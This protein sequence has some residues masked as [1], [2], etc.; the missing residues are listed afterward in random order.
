M[1]TDIP[2]SNSAY[3]STDFVSHYFVFR[4]KSLFRPD[5]TLQGD[6]TYELP[7]LHPLFYIPVGEGSGNH[8]P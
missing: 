7:G 3:G 8:T 1:K 2:I 5:T 6:V 4:M